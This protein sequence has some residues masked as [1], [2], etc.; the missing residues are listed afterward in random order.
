MEHFWLTQTR[1]LVDAVLWNSWERNISVMW[2]T[3]P[4]VA[5]PVVLRHLLGIQKNGRRSV[6]LKCVFYTTVMAV[7]IG[8]WSVEQ[9]L[10]MPFNKH[11]TVKLLNFKKGL[12][13]EVQCRHCQEYLANTSM[14]IYMKLDVFQLSTRNCV[15]LPSASK[16]RWKWNYWIR[17]VCQLS[18]M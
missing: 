1:I 14:M 17:P 11:R 15:P 10:H 8:A 18:V 6:S 2:L 7:K 9:C 5:F 13:I 12:Y 3:S 16:W 4:N